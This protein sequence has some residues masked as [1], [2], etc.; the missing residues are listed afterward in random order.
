MTS[1]LKAGI[2]LSLTEIIGDYGAKIQNPLL[3]YGGY[4]LLAHEL[5]SF[6]KNE[7]LVLVNANWDGIS[8]ICT[9]IMGMALGE[10]FNQKQ[11]MGLAL[12]TTGIF[13]IN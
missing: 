1:P 9:M 4:M 3:A 7:S 6:L 8:N 10:R 2:F 11:Y 5:L 12:I 13:L